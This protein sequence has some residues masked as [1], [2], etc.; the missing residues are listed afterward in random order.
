MKEFDKYFEK[1][2]NLNQ[3]F[4]DYADIFD[5][6]NNYRQQFLGNILTTESD[7]LEALAKLTG[8]ISTLQPLLQTAQAYKE[9]QEDGEFLRLR[10]E[11]A[12]SKEKITDA[13]T[14]TSAHY[15][16]RN[17]IKI[18]NTIDAYVSNCEKSI[19]TVQTLLKYIKKE[20]MR[21]E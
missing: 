15:A 12:S 16:V 9:I 14:K 7:L 18:R 1:E 19:I 21:T 4:T 5:I 8:A 13:T 2:E 10:N 20:E 11:A 3:I 6:L 17:Y